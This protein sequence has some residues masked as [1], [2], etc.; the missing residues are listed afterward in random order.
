MNSMRDI[1]Y[2]CVFVARKLNKHVSTSIWKERINILPSQATFD[3]FRV[4]KF[5]PAYEQFNFFGFVPTFIS[6]YFTKINEIYVCVSYVF[7]MLRIVL[8]LF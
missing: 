4:N 5:A 8:I 1:R 6:L 2:T 3:Y 7:A